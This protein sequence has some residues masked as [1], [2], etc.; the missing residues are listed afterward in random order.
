MEIIY[1]DLY[2]DTKDWEDGK[3]RQDLMIELIKIDKDVE[4][5]D[6]DIGMGADFPSVLVE[7]FKKIDWRY[8]L[9]TGIAGVFFLGEKINKNIDAWKEIIGKFKLAIKNFHPTRIDEKGALLLVLDDLAVFSEKA[10]EIDIS[11]QIIPFTPALKGKVTL[12]KQPDVLYIV[13]VKVPFKVY[14][15]GIKSNTK[16]VFRNEYSTEWIDF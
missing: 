9:G 14:V 16:I 11:I 10:K 8:L 12:D 6:V 2:Y 7:I 5:K 3:F 13:T 15:V 1:P 4:A